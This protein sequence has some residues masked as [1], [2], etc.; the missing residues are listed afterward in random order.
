MLPAIVRKRLIIII[1][2][3]QYGHDHYRVSAGVAKLSTE[4]SKCLER[5]ATVVY[6]TKAVVAVSGVKITLDI[7]YKTKLC[8]YNNSFHINYMYYRSAYSFRIVTDTHT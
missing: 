5:D 2:H 8:C 6:N 1:I 7:E 3:L 4:A